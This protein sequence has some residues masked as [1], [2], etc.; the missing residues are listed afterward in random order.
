[1][2]AVL[3]GI[4]ALYLLCAS[5]SAFAGILP[6]PFGSFWVGYNQ[7]WF[8]DYYPNWLTSNP[9]YNHFYNPPNLF[10][11]KFETLTGNSLH[12][13]TLPPPSPPSLMETWFQG[14][15]NGNA[16]IVR[17][18]VFPA[19]QGIVPDQYNP[20]QQTVG[21]T[22][23]LIANLNTVFSCARTHGLMVYVT[24]LNGNDATYS[25]LQTYFKNLFNNSVAREAFKNSALGPL[26]DVL[27]ANQAVIYAFDLINE[28]EAPLNAGYIPNGWTGARAWIQDMAAFVK[29]R[30]T[31]WL[32][33]V[34]S[35][36]GWGWAV[37]EITFGLFS[38]LGP[39]FFYDLHVYTDSGT[40]SGETALCNK[41]SADG[42]PIVLGE[43]GQK[44][45]VVDDDLQKTATYNF[46]SGATP[47]QHCF[48][49]A[50]AW[51]YEEGN[52]PG[53]E[54]W[55]SYLKPDGIT[56][57]KAYCTIKKFPASWLCPP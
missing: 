4:A 6:Q 8:G 18:W 51:M 12:L 44:S 46:L 1:M 41:V 20:P 38:G 23:D 27:K 16:K 54:P 48:S 15:S 30:T 39:N 19:L 3:R 26:L 45:H 10:P 9:V 7:A 31:P 43:F 42:V 28:I 35:S 14:M 21:V 50:L 22:S 56:P 49:S 29:A 33:P 57:R 47:P 11:S 2:K 52:V 17:I 24:A 25:P 32:L 5:T 40:Y 37:Q 55:F 53:S 13:C 36:A 34:T